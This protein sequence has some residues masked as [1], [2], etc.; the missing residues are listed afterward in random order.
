MSVSNTHVTRFPGVSSN[1]IYTTLLFDILR[2]AW[3]HGES[4]ELDER[5]RGAFESLTGK[6]FNPAVM[7]MAGQFVVPVILHG[8]PGHGKTS[9]VKAAA[10]R[11]AELLGMNLV[12]ATDVYAGREVTEDD[13]LLVVEE[14]AGQHSAITLTGIPSKEETEQYGTVMRN[15]SDMRIPASRKAGVS[16][17]L[18]DDLGN[19]A[20]NLIP[21]LL[22]VF[23]ER[24][25]GS[26]YLGDNAMVIGTTNL[27]KAL[28]GAIGISGLG[29][30]LSNRVRHF[31]VRDN[32]NDWIARQERKIAAQRSRHR[33]NDYGFHAF[34]RR[35]TDLFNQ[36]DVPASG[37]FVSPRSLSLFADHLPYLIEK[38]R[39]LAD[40]NGV[41]GAVDL[42]E[43]HLEA[44][45][46]LGKEA[47]ERIT[48]YY[49]SYFHGVTQIS[50]RLFADEPLGEDGWRDLVARV[51]EGFGGGVSD[52]EIEFGNSLCSDLLD[53]VAARIVGDSWDQGR[54]ALGRR[55]RQQM[56]PVARLLKEGGINA[57]FIAP[58]LSDM[59]SRLVNQLDESFIEEKHGHKAICFDLKKGIFT[60]F[61]SAGYDRVAQEEIANALTHARDFEDLVEDTLDAPGL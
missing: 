43:I 3:T 4:P 29:T 15:L 39:F 44:E 5:V 59:A 61:T 23:N 8:P 7:P 14:M 35:N 31:L 25:Y 24:R 10:E 46:L 57:S 45:A 34:M 16:I 58:R 19:A 12:T 28:D 20:P 18:Y 38:A 33:L 37:G 1:S 53:N 42:E 22:N 41:G 54:N 30:A 51:R 6:P 2:S 49:Q 48:A 32:L 60:A 40:Q 27:G 26:H 52:R 56:E 50:N 13:L 17:W 21:A 36:E 11:A 55:M 9:V 47:A